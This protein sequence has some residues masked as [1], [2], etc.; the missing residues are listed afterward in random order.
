MRIEGLQN[1]FEIF[2]EF[3]LKINGVEITYN[4]AVKMYYNMDEA[5]QI[6]FAQF[7]ADKVEYEIIDIP[8]ITHASGYNLDK[9]IK[10]TKTGQKPNSRRNSRAG[11]KR[12]EYIWSSNISNFTKDLIAQKYTAEAYAAKNGLTLD[13]VWSQFSAE[14]I[15]EM[16]N[17]GVNIPQNIVDAAETELQSK[18]GNLEGVE[19]ESEEGEGNDSEKTEKETFLELIPKAKKNIDKCHDKEAKIDEKI[20]NLVQNNGGIQK[21]FEEKMEKQKDVLKEYEQMIREWRVLQNKIN[22][23]EELTDTEAR[24]YAHI[25][26]MLEDK[27]GSAADFKLDKLSIARNLNEINI[28]AVLGEQLA[29]ETIEI[30]DQ[31]ADYVSET[32]YKSTR[33]QITGEIGFLRA[34]TAML[35]G[36]TLAKEANEVGHETKDYTEDTADSI[37]DIAGLLGVEKMIINPSTQ[38]EENKPEDAESTKEIQETEGNEPQENLTLTENKQETIKAAEEKNNSIEEDFIINDENVLDLI[39]ENIDINADLLKQVKNSLENTKNADEDEDYAKMSLKILTDII[40]KYKKEEEKRQEEIAAKEEENKRAQ[41]KIEELGG[42]ENS[43]KEMVSKLVPNAADSEENPNQNEID[44]QQ[45]IIDRNT[46]DIKAI[47]EQSAEEKERI[48]NTTSSYKEKLNKAIPEETK[49]LA[50]DIEYKDEIIP[51]DKVRIAFTNSSGKTLRKMG[52]Y[53]VTVGMEQIALLQIKKGLRNIAKGTISTGIG[54]GAEIVSKTPIPKVA[55]KTTG[56]AVNAE[57]NAINTLTELDNRI[58]EVTGD[59]AADEEISNPEESANGEENSEG[60]ENGEAGQDPAANTTEEPAEANGS[61]IPVETAPSGETVPTEDPNAVEVSID[62]EE[63][64]TVKEPTGD[65]NGNTV[66]GGGKEMSEEEKAQAAG[67][68]AKKE[69]KNQKKQTDKQEDIVKDTNRSAKKDAKESKKIEKDEKKN[70]KQLEKEAKKIEQDIKKEEQDLVKMVKE[71]EEAAKKQEELLVRYEILTQ[72]NETIAA[73]EE[74]KKSIAAPAQQSDN[75]NNDNGIASATNSFGMTDSSKSSTSDNLDILNANNQEI[76]TIASQ[77]G[78]AGNKITRNRVKIL[79]IE[80]HIKTSTKKF[81][82]KTKLKQKKIKDQQKK[83]MKKQKKLQK[84]LAA[85]GIAENVFS[86]TSTT[87]MVLTE[88]GTPMI[89]AG[90]GFI[91]AG[92]SLLCWPTT[93]LGIALITKGTVL[94]VNGTTLT[95]VGSVLST[96]GLYGTVACGVTKAAINI[97]NGNLAAGLMSLGQTA[98][99]AVAGATSTGSAANNTFGFVSQGLSVVS[100]SAQ[101]VNNVRVVSGKEAN[102]VMSKVGTIAGVGSALAGSASTISELGKNGASSFNKASQI[103]GVVGST[104]SSASQLMSEFGWGDEKTANILGSVGGA[105]S[106]IG[107]IGQ[108]ASNKKDDMDNK[109][110]ENTNEAQQN[111]DGN[112]NKTNNS[113]SNNQD[114]KVETVKKAMQDKKVMAIADRASAEMGVSPADFHKNL[115]EFVANNST[116]TQPATNSNATQNPKSVEEV[117]PEG[118]AATTETRSNA[119][120]NTKTEQTKAQE[121][122]KRAQAKEDIRRHEELVDTQRAEAEGL[123]GEARKNVIENGASAEFADVDD[124]ALKEK[125]SAAKANGASADEIN[126]LTAEQQRRADFK[127]SAQNAQA[128]KT[129]LKNYREQKFNKIEKVIDTVGKTTSATASIMSLFA[130][131]ENTAT[132]KKVKNKGSYDSRYLKANKYMATSASNDSYFGGGHN[133]DQKRRFKKFAKR[134]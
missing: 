9:E 78:I 51:E 59:K 64:S 33:E 42:G 44:K 30:G 76:T 23:G 55:E 4:D 87:G 67:E 35:N 85:V 47:N 66:V 126:K 118:S 20:T 121:K 65:N 13:E 132:G 96:I 73:E 15:M 36:K 56:I 50:T 108:I 104:T 68:M 53:R 72:E 119:E 100:N 98:I 60:E 115:N 49:N 10:V 107:S 19:G 28:L 26:G 99:A 3:Y 74:Q 43:E 110:K 22:N 105:M 37:G 88:I 129:T 11:G 52:I 91:A 24:K 62:D 46:T 117:K 45:A 16:F 112:N 38:P 101:L 77:F 71:S 109:N 133:D 17:N 80:K 70:A 69:E 103:V 82:K 29:D 116:S 39:D 27:N 113:E 79:K 2:Q 92:E 63:P 120:D 12:G 86:I 90:Q 41:E 6:D 58:T 40:E 48:I 32:N 7:C 8:Y 54:V 131:N 84:Q 81:Q 124:A 14:E 111:S 94:E 93:A 106:M 34:I 25:T 102:G 130:S 114:K 57:N 21:S 75:T 95:T 125:I 122:E 83:E 134:I 31:L 61:T 5:T 1:K 128:G 89:P 97:A 18:T 123:K 127:A